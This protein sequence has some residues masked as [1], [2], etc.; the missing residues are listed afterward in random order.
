MSTNL[1]P[2]ELSEFFRKL[3]E[4][5]SFIKRRRFNFAVVLK[6]KFDDL[7]IVKLS[8]KPVTHHVHEFTTEGGKLIF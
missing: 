5:F 1:R 6:K 3:I 4:M 8:K 7:A 2:R